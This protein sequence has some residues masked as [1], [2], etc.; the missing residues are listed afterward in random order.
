MGI[1]Q[2]VRVTITMEPPCVTELD[3]RG[4]GTT[5]AGMN[6]GHVQVFGAGGGKD[7]GCGRSV[8]QPRP[9][10]ATVSLPYS[11][12]RSRGRR[13]LHVIAHLVSRF[14]LERR[15]LG[16]AH[17]L[18]SVY[19]LSVHISRLSC[20]PHVLALTASRAPRLTSQIYPSRLP[21][22]LPPVNATLI[23]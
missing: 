13:A 1:G 9:F 22:A 11:A 5:S 10:A 12:R 16:R 3:N 15:R 4:K 19:P 20:T 21:R 8:S 2:S 23:V 18:P 6:S 14:V 17:D 7:T